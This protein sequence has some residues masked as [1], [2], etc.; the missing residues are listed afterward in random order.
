MS[1]SGWPGAIRTLLVE[2]TAGGVEEFEIVGGD[3]RLRIRRRPG[4][5]TIAAPVAVVE[6]AIGPTLTAPISGIFYR[7]ASPGAD[8]FVRDGDELAPGQPIGLIEA[9]KVFNE[10]RADRA[11]RVV[12]FLV[13]NGQ[14]VR[15]GDPLLELEEVE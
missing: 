10:V 1:A 9:M 14:L 12:R 11:G 13:E 15:A 3:S 7:A 8:P 2:L 5:L 4:R 6:A